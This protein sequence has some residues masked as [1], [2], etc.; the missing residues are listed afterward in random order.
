MSEQTNDCAECARLALLDALRSAMNTARENG[1]T[2]LVAECWED[3][4]FNQRHQHKHT[5]KGAT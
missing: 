5:C 1:L 4:Q 2:G 3:I